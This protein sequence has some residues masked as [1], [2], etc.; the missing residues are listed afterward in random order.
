M[1]KKKELEKYSVN[2]VLNDAKPIAEKLNKVLAKDGY[3][4]D[5]NIKIDLKEK[6]ESIKEWATANGIDE[7]PSCGRD[8]EYND[9]LQDDSYECYRYIGFDCDDSYYSECVQ[10]CHVKGSSIEDLKKDIAR[11][12]VF[13]EEVRDYM[14]DFK[15]DISDRILNSDA[16]AK[17]LLL[18]S[19]IID[20]LNKYKRKNY[21]T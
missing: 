20:E 19:M 3:I 8:W 17:F 13:E 4:A 5:I 7:C 12:Y 21:G 10:C 2:K 18:F 15:N 6:K 16:R 1:N 9:D 11:G 14:E